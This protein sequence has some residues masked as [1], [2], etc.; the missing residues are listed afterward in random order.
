MSL[1]PLARLVLLILSSTLPTLYAG[2]VE[3][4]P[5]TAT[6]RVE[7]SDAALDCPDRGELTSRVQAILQRTLFSTTSEDQLEVQVHFSRTRDEYSASVRSQWYSR[8]SSTLRPATISLS[9]VASVS[10]GTGKLL[11]TRYAP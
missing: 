4:A 6:I 5:L 11:Y 3:A 2:R 10:S 8:T 1:P 9:F 7:R